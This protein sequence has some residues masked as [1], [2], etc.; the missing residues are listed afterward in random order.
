ML[1]KGKGKHIENLHII[2]LCEADLNF[3]L[4]IIW[5]K[6]LIRNALNHLDKAQFAI[7]GQTCHNAIISKQLYLDLSWQTFSPGLMVDYDAKTAFDS[8][9]SGIANIA[10]QRF[11]LPSIA[12]NFMYNL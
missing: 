11:S 6:H 4:H 7:L 9:I 12:G 2:Q 10:C 3:V 8:V 1:E 5:G